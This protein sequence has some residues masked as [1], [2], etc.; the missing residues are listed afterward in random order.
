MADQ[1]AQY[2]EEAVGAGHPTKADVINRLA[3]VEHNTDGTHKADATLAKAAAYTVAAADKGKL[4]RATGGTWTLTLLAAATAG[5]GFPIRVE[6]GGAGV[7]TVDGNGAELVGP[8]ATIKLA[9]RDFL[10]LVCDGSNWR[11]AGHRISAHFRATMAGAQSINDATATK[12]QFA[13]EDADPLGD[14]DPAVN[15]RYT[16]SVPGW[17]VVSAGL[18]FTG[19][20][21]DGVRKNLSIGK[22]GTV[23]A[24]ADIRDGAASSA[25]FLSGT[26][27]VRMNGTADYLEAFVFHAQGAAQNVGGTTEGN[28]FFT[29]VLV[30]M[31]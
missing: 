9:Q 24:L 8:A 14:Y 12:L 22:N 26:K 6:N 29:A 4:I 27:A 1:R 15:Y 13:T 11:I 18:N 23:S 20:F 30:A 17:Y 25:T 28:A 5:D 10:I 16:P 2:T 3:L 31:D 7:V 21:S 19:A